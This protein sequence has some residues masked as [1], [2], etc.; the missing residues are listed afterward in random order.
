MLVVPQIVV[1]PEKRYDRQGRLRRGARRSDGTIGR[2]LALFDTLGIRKRANQVAAYLSNE[3]REELSARMNKWEV[4]QSQ[5]DIGGDQPMLRLTAMRSDQIA[6]R[7]ALIQLVIAK[8]DRTHG[9]PFS[10]SAACSARLPS[11]STP[12]NVLPRARAAAP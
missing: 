7:I 4:S 1:R 12:M 11:S 3:G 9:A 10:R 5:V 6:Q 8:H 2:T